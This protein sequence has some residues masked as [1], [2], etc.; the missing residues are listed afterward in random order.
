MPQLTIEDFQDKVGQTYQVAL[1]DQEIAL[2]LTRV[3]PR[4]SNAPVQVRKPFSLFF[5][6][7]GEVLLE[8]K[9]HTMKHGEL[10][11]LSIFLVPIGRDDR[12]DY[13]YQAVFQ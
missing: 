4:Q 13:N 11:E 1:E 7:P 5:K 3:A 2:I 6:G 12:G 9:T 10:G 8:Q